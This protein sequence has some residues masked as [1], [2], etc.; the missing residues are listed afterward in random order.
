M[1]YLLSLLN[2]KK[3]FVI[4]VTVNTPRKQILLIFYSSLLMNGAVC[5]SRGLKLGHWNKV[6]TT[7]DWIRSEI[8]QFG[9]YLC[10][11]YNCLKIF[12]LIIT[13]QATGKSSFSHPLKDTEETDHQCVENRKCCNR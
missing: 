8:L 9:R 4:R 11:H 3:C 13:M 7:Q 2:C 12:F 6:P 1:L 5:C 10:G